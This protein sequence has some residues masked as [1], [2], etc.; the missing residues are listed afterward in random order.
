MY[1][2]GVIANNRLWVKEILTKD[3]VII[4]SE[5]VQKT[6]MEINA[7]IKTVIK[8]EVFLL[9]ERYQSSQLHKISTFG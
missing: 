4:K 9:E 3:S 2:K 6:F 7:R 1:A 8:S 5:N